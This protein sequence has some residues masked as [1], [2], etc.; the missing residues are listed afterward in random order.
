MDFQK[1]VF[2]H[3]ALQSVKGVIVT[4]VCWFVLYSLCYTEHRLGG[5]C[6]TSWL[7]LGPYVQAVGI[8]HDS[9][10]CEFDPLTFLWT[11]SFL[12]PY[13]HLSFRGTAVS[14]VWTAASLFLFSS[15]SLSL[16]SFL[17]KNNVNI[18]IFDRPRMGATVTLMTDLFMNASFHSLIRL[19]HSV[20]S[21]LPS[22]SSYHVSKAQGSIYA[23]HVDNLEG[24]VCPKMKV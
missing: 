9:L 8:Y 11:F 20:S 7:M 3:N 17:R 5:R 16:P 12:R 15:S 10:C 21:V 23:R 19:S 2:P 6:C 4:C 22:M 18:V 24:L 14:G 1:Q 13:L